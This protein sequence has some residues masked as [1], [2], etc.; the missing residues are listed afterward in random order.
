MKIKRLIKN[1]L[2]LLR[3]ACKLSPKNMVFTIIS[4]IV[5]TSKNLLAVLIPGILVNIL[6]NSQSFSIPLI[7]VTAF[8]LITT[9][10]DMTAKYFSL[11]LTSLGYALNNYGALHVAQKGMKNDYKHWDTASF[12]E[13]NLNAV[14][15][16]W[17]FMGITDVYFENLLSGILSVLAVSYIIAQVNWLVLVIL[18]ALVVVTVIIDRKNIK[19]Q[20]EMQKEM[21]ALRKKTQYDSYVL[22]DLRFGKE[23]RMFGAVSFFKDKYWKSSEDVMMFQ[24]KRELKSLKYS[25]PNSVIGLVESVLVYIASIMQY[26]AGKIQLGFLLVYYGAIIQLK[27]AINTVFNFYLDIAEIDEIYGDIK[28]FLNTEETLRLGHSSVNKDSGFELEVKNVSFRYPESKEYTLKNISFTISGNEKICIV[29]DNGSGKTTLV[30]LLLRLYDVTDGEILLN[31]VNIKEYDYDEY[32]SVF[33][34]VFQ[35]FQLHAFTIR[36]N[37]AFDEKDND[38]K[39]YELLSMYKLDNVI[40]GLNNKLDTML[41]KQLDENGV[42]LSG[43]EKQKL[44]MV[45]AAYKDARALVLDEPTA[46]IDPIAEADF[47]ALVRSLFADKP[48]VFVSHRMSSAKISDKILVFDN[49]CLIECGGFNELIQKGGLFADMYRQQADL[50]KKRA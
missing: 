13:K 39:I 23:I 11:K 3:L 22:S 17:I 9:V 25:I 24:H 21:A 48:M 29:G 43:G 18:F 40:K 5:N 32:M 31:G 27:N 6:T 41:T 45:R 14:Q 46:N 19:E 4:A 49:G 26:S 50:Y 2:E 44:A 34:P 35:D 12:M 20:H 16:T 36:E 38:E 33:A 10:A 8:C 28:S 42:D 47:Y 1:S 7:V 30:K 37:I 15:G